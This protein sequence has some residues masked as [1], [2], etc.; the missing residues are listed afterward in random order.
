MNDLVYILEALN[1]FYNSAHWRSKG[2]LFYQDHLLFQ[3]LYDGISDEIDE[4][5][6]L[7]IGFTSDDSFVEP[8][9]FNEKVQFYTPEGGADSKT[10]LIRAQGLEEAL[11]AQISAFSEREVGVGIYNQL[12]EIA[13][14]HTRN[15]YLIKQT[16]R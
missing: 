4:L 9:L 2:S 10:N 8:K 5:V 7:I 14:H 12:A 6:E 3:R 11:I 15:L 1:V 16:L 13:D